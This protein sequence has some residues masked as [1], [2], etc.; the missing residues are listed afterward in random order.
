[1]PILCPPRCAAAPRTAAL[2]AGI[3]LALGPA[4]ASAQLFVAVGASG[5]IDGTVVPAPDCDQAF[6]VGTLVLCN[7]SGADSAQFSSAALAQPSGNLLGA[8]FARHDGAATSTT[9]SGGASW[10]ER[11]SFTTLTRPVVVR[12]WLDI[13]GTQGT[14]ALSGDG[15]ELVA[16]TSTFIRMNV[17]REGDVADPTLFDEWLVARYRLDRGA[18]IVD[19]Y[20]GY[21]RTRRGVTLPFETVPGYPSSPPFVFVLDA[22]TSYYDFNWNFATNATVAAG[23]TGDAVTRYE[24]PAAPD[25]TPLFDGWFGGS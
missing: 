15:S 14:N 9:G 10:T 23:Q 20:T 12:Q 4:T 2:F 1:M 8:A 19:E 7:R 5:F 17:R 21:E 18:G 3:V 6:E 13:S 22:G 16:W 24:R 25:R 11:V